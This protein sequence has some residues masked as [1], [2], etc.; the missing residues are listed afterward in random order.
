MSDDSVFCQ[1]CG[2]SV[3][4]EAK[5]VCKVCGYELED[6]SV[7]CQQCGASVQDEQQTEDTAVRLCAK[8]G[9]QLDDDAV[10]CNECGASVNGD[11][12]PESV[13]PVL[14]NN[15]P[16]AP[17]PPPAPIPMPASIPV[18]KKIRYCTKC[19][20]EIADGDEFCIKCG[21]RAD[22]G[23]KKGA[24]LNGL[25][26]KKLFV[27]VAAVV[28]VLCIVLIIFNSMM[29]RPDRR[30]LSAFGKTLNSNS[31]K[32]KIELYE[33]DYGDVDKIKINAEVIGKLSL[34]GD[35]MLYAKVDEGRYEQ[36]IAYS[37]DTVYFEDDGEY[38]A[39]DVNFDDGTDKVEK[40][41]DK[42]FGMDTQE[43]LELLGRILTDFHK[44][45]EDSDFVKDY[46]Y[47]KNKNQY[48][49]EI[50]LFDFLDALEDDYDVDMD[51]SIRTWLKN[52]DSDFTVKISIGLTDNNKYVSSLD[53]EFIYESERYAI[54]FNADF[55]DFGKI[56]AEDSKAQKLIDKAEKYEKDSGVSKSKLK[57]A[58]GNAKTAYNAAAE[59]MAD[60]ETQG[61]SRN[62]CLDR[63]GYK[64]IDCTGPRPSDAT[65]YI[66]DVMQYNDE[67][68][69]VIIFSAYINGQNSFAVHWRSSMDSKEIG[70][71]PDA[72]TYDYAKSNT[73]Y[74]GEYNSSYDY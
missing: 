62:D 61:Y 39:E 72:I 32:A 47:R 50:D 66:Y 24:A 37:D 74:W 5:N 15:A 36:A 14:T 16:S 34:E 9:A 13:A 10:F 43:C 42:K 6:D 29:S 7:F 49:Y 60:M 53:M 23:K 52:R 44:N 30:I 56:K 46:K 4:K 22:D 71:Y 11:V 28:A 35:F 40:T 3:E 38:Y 67:P 31:L 18:S 59:Y 73:I 12:L 17:V 20:S 2:A 55:D 25:K 58:N 69:Y 41:L 65:A 19:G 26:S 27:P 21:E 33:E 51:K 57:T 48:D 45:G 54:G 63:I 1:S 8:C 68:G 70:Q 64:V